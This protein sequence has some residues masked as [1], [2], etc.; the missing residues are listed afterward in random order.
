MRA[1]TEAVDTVD[2]G[3]WSENRTDDRIECGTPENTRVSRR[4]RS[5]AE[6]TESSI[7]SSM[8]EQVI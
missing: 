6:D 3:I 2:S 8:L 4:R 5:F 7:L 1:Y